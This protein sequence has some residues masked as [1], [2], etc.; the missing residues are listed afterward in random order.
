M[1]L[2][3][4]ECADEPRAAC[5]SRAP[6]AAPVTGGSVSTCEDTVV[7]EHGAELLGEEPGLVVQTE[8]EFGSLAGCTWA[9][10]EC[11]EVEEDVEAAVAKF[12]D[13]AV[14]CGGAP[15]GAKPRFS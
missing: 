4:E 12:F 6:V 2:F 9:R 1:G 8:E 14:A 3:C 7:V 15:T 11:A 10:D 13:D 5:A